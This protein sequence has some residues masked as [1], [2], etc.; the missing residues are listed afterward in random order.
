MFVVL[1]DWITIVDRSERGGK[2]DS[3]FVAGIEKFVLETRR[4]REL[5]E[6]LEASRSTARIHTI[7]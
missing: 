6:F 5:F 2:P 7:G 1:D 4:Q 3:S